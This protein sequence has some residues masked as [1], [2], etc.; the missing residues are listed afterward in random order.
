MPKPRVPSLRLHKPSG[1]AVVT[2]SGR[3][4]YCGTYGSPEAQQV[5]EEQLA[6]WLANGRRLESA[7][8]K[9]QSI[10]VGKLVCMYVDWATEHYAGRRQHKNIVSRIRSALQPLVEL[11]RTLP[12]ADFSPLKLKTVRQKIVDTPPTHALSRKVNGERVVERR[13]HEGKRPAIKTVNEKTQVVVSAFNW[14]ASEELI[15]GGV[16]HA[17]KAVGNLR[18]GE[19]GVEL[20]RKVKPVADEHVDAT[21][22]HITSSMLRTLVEVIRYTGART[23]EICIMRPCDLDR[24]GRNWI[25]RPTQHKTD[26]HGHDRVIVLGPC[27]QRAVLP[28]LDGCGDDEFIFSPARSDRLRIVRKRKS[29]RRRLGEKYTPNVVR[30]CI[31]RACDRADVPRWGPLELRH[32]FATKVRAEL[33]LQAASA[34]LGHAGEAV[35]LR[36]AETN[37]QLADQAATLCG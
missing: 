21:L 36:Y 15:P 27:A 24:S 17:L 32:T 19:P 35:T 29:R 4:I 31:H 7:T 2:L 22:K 25:Y 18:R 11:Y 37:M 10:T 26:L 12:A 23:N 6:R 33:S 1:K 8:S 14:A 13:P 16:V 28:H 5:Y 30:R 3:D 20:P 34:A 9:P